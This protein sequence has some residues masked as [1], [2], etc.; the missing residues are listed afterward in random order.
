MSS[1]RVEPKV[2]RPSR[3][4][5]ASSTSAMRTRVPSSRR[6]SAGQL[7]TARA[8]D[9]QEA[10]RLRLAPIDMSGSWT[11]SSGA[12]GLR[13]VVALKAWVRLGSNI[14]SYS[15]VHP[16]GGVA[17]GFQLRSLRVVLG[18]LLLA[19]LFE[20]LLAAGLVS[21]ARNLRSDLDLSGLQLLGDFALQADE[22]HSILHRR[23]RHLHVVGVVEHL[24]EVVG[25]DPAVQ[26]L[27]LI[28][29]ILATEHCE[30]R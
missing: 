26:Q 27:T 13:Q 22:E 10:R 4:F 2:G 12:V 1:R 8:A 29:L 6:R 28:P 3:S 5:M 15:Q 19:L 17:R 25:R 20:L 14:S 23:R 7:G 24:Y 9:A 30:A 16:S 11:T 21:R 18:G